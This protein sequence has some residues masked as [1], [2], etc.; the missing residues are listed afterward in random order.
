MSLKHIVVSQEN[1][2]QLKEC[3]DAGDSF[4]DVITN[5][6]KKLERLEIFYDNVKM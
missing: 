5:I 1:Y 4:N 2:Q 6:L 3:G